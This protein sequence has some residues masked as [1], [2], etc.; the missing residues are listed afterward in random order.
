[1]TPE[2]NQR[3]QA[4]LEEVATLVY[5][6]IDQA[7]LSKQEYPE[8]VLRQLMSEQFSLQ[9]DLVLSGRRQEFNQVSSDS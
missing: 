6:Q 2:K 7:E 9:V 1:M 3:V 4:C 5:E 8:Q